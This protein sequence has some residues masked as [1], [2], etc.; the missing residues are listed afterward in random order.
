MALIAKRGKSGKGGGSGKRLGRSRNSIDTKI[1][2]TLK[3]HNRGSG[4]HLIRDYPYQNQEKDE[5]DLPPLLGRQCLLLFSNDL[6]KPQRGP[7]AD[8]HA[9]VSTSLSLCRLTAQLASEGKA[10]QPTHA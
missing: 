1:G 7:V 6:A 3:G 5:V 4:S 2:Q 8:L 9:S 10:A